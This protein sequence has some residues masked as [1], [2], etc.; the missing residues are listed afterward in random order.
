LVGTVYSV[1]STKATAAA[2]QYR[3]YACCI[4][5][6]RY[7]DPPAPADGCCDLLALLHG[8]HRIAWAPAAAD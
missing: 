3:R 4:A 2:L 8:L 6:P 5:I 1:T 7:A